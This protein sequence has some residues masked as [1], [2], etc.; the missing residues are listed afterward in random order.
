MHR[1]LAGTL[2]A[3]AVF[4]LF[5]VGV[6]Q[7]V[8]AQGSLNAGKRVALVIGNGD[9][10]NVAPL[11]NP[12]SDARA[13]EA[14]LKR[15]GFEVISGIDLDRSG[16]EEKLREFRKVASGSEVTLVFYSGHGLQVAGQNWLLPVSAKLGSDQDLRYEAVPLEVVLSEAEAATRLRV[17]IL[18]ACRDNPFKQKLAAAMGTRSASL[19]KGLARIE[20]SGT[21][22]LIAYSTKADEVAADG[23]GPTSPYTTALLNHLE[24]PSL[25]VRFLFGKVRDEVRQ[26]T[27]GKQVPAVYGDWGGEPIYLATAVGAAI[28]FAR[29]KVEP[30]PSPEEANEKG[31]VALRRGDYAEAMRWYRQAADQGSAYAQHTMG[32]FYRFGDGVAQDDAETMRW[33]RKAA[34]QGFAEAQDSI[35]NLYSNGHGVT[36]DRAEA[37]RWYIKAADQGDAERQRMVGVRY[38]AEQNYAEAMRWYR[39]A[40]DQ[41]NYRAQLS[42]GA[43][44]ERGEGVKRDPA[45][46]RRW[47]RKAADNG[48]K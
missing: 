43:L 10:K 9:Y 47:Y 1:K 32:M 39:K 5:V 19:G 31:E 30:P 35:G 20:P 34:D 40:A 17:V 42:I 38:A 22:T 7:G 14:A 48:V 21:D 16:F 8:F 29:P 25:D 6:P 4:I 11:K 23:S 46:A 33:Y 15:I 36:K 27:Q 45:E 2:A 44:Y 28:P 18:D 3:L 13:V 26:A 24:T 41:G 37:M 12:L